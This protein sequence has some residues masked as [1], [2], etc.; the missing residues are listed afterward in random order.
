MDQNLPH[1]ARS[2]ESHSFNRGFLF[3]H[4]AYLASKDSKE[5]DDKQYDT[6]GDGQSQEGLVVCIDSQYWL[7]LGM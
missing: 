1:S 7:V 4:L 3:K 6:C 5:K 2:A